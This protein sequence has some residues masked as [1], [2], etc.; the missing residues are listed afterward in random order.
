MNRFPPR[1]L[2]VAVDLAEPSLSALEAAKSLARRWDAS[3]EVVHVQ[4]PPVVAAWVG[5]GL[6]PNLPPSAREPE[7]R[8]RERLKKAAAGFPEA[9]LKLRVIP[10]WPPNELADI[11]ASGEAELIVVGT[12]GYAG[13]DR[14]AFGSASEAVVRRAR[15]PVLA[16][17]E[18]RAPL[19]VERVL[20][21][22][23][24]SPYATRALRYA[25]ELARSLGARLH[26]LRV[27]EPG[28]PVCGRPALG[29]TLDAVLGP[30]ADWTLRVRPGNARRHIVREANSGRYG[31]VV[32][33][34][35]RRRFSS[36]LI[37][38]TTVERVLRHSTIPVLAVPSGA[39]PARLPIARPSAWVAGKIFSP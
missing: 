13:L 19:R 25:R 38:G 7:H 31:L 22:W 1:R 39:I 4:S 6:P 17:H 26:V 14:V 34:A 24:G 2:L 36:D 32:L 15:V 5:P 28:S 11:A 23:N 9:R 20:A 27:V 37:L 30:G 21:P 18:Q 33:S 35:H 12:H 10:G 16:V 29:R 8:L 3:L